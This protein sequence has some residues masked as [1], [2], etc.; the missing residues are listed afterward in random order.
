MGST[1]GDQ[2]P[3]GAASQPAPDQG[4][5]T[6]GAN[7]AQPSDT[8]P[9][10][11]APNGSVTAGSN[12]AG[13]PSSGPGDVAAGSQPNYNAPPNYN[14]PPPGTAGATT[15]PPPPTY[16]SGTRLYTSTQNGVQV[17]SNGP[18]P[19]TRATRERFP[20]LSRAGRRTRP[21]GN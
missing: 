1:S 18:V 2:P 8:Q 20:P 5:A 19:D 12:V 14:P 4:A 21:R 3:N 9:S 11:A 6:T 16:S 7:T 17:V 10:A 15:A 13:Q